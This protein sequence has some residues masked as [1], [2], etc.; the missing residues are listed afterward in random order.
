MRPFPAAL[1]RQDLRD[2]AGYSS[3]RT[4]HTGPPA[5]IWL[6]ANEA[7]TASTAD[8]TG[9][10]RRYPE[11]QP[12]ELLAAL[13]AAY[14]VPAERLV[15][16]RGSDEGIELLVRA[17]CRPGGD[18]VVTAPPT[19][20]MYAVSARLHGVP[21]VDVPQRDDVLPDGTP[22]W[23][24]DVDALAAAAL[25]AGA[26][27]VFVASP[28]N[29]TGSR[30]PLADVSRL[31]AA[32]AGRAVV[33]LDEAYQEF[34]G[35]PASGLTLL[36]EHA[37]LAVLRTLSKA[38]GLAAAR[39]GVCVTHPELAAVLRRVQA[40]YPVPGPVAHLA[41]AALQ[42]A[43]LAATARRVRTTLAQRDRLR[44]ALA[45]DP[46]VSTLYHSDANFLLVRCT[47]ADAVLADLGDAGIVVRDLRS[48]PGLGDALRVTVGSP[49]ET[50]A[51][52]AAL[53]PRT[54]RTP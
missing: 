14:Q 17:T 26:R 21:V 18:A 51:L 2:F 23:R 34:G 49:A 53:T 44:A 25:R 52:V 33:V 13:A 47:D 6:N 3:A 28:G 36:E 45:A 9:G 41:V 35:D 43:A 54:V 42:P 27:L 31:A 50:G 7:A 22:V 4:S 30:V 20:G 24:V 5:R 10:Y 48:Q 32:L 46:R 40:P 38:H 16:G 37:N 19:F 8:P 11:P 12:P 15:V 29:P 1:V 39:V